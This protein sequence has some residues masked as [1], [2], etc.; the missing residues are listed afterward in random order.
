MIVASDGLWDV[1]KP[2]KAV[3]SVRTMDSEAAANEL[4]RWEE[5]EFSMINLLQRADGTPPC[6]QVVAKGRVNDD[7]SVFIIDIMESKQ[8]RKGSLLFK[9]PFST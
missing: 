4:V 1:V 9:L 8:V 5:F 7:T 6:R 3:K 2:G